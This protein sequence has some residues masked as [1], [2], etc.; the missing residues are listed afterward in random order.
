MKNVDETGVMPP[1]LFDMTLRPRDNHHDV[2]LHG[3]GKGNPDP[4]AANALAAP[5]AREKTMKINMAPDG[6]GN[7]PTA[8]GRNNQSVFNL[9]DHF[10]KIKKDKM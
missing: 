2:N 10:V 4:N 3:E 6:T 5:P 9:I 8:A 7:P 1:K